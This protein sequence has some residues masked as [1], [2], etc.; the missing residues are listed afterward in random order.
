MWTKGTDFGHE[1]LWS[2]L[3]LVHELMALTQCPGV[4]VYL[5]PRAARSRTEHPH[6]NQ[7]SGR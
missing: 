7:G 2:N 5:H 3:S 1:I 4:G 6:R